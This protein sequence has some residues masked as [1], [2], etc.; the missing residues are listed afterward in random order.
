MNTELI[1]S[2]LKAVIAM[3]ESILLEL[4]EEDCKHPKDERTD[5][6]T[7][8]HEAWQCN[9]CGYTFGMEEGE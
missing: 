9:T 6:S 8:G 2:Q 4:D 5:L 7:M 3:A 1:K